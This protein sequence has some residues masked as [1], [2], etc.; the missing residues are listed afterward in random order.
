MHCPD[1]LGLA[2]IYQDS[3][4]GVPF[5]GYF[6]AVERPR[7]TGFSF[8]VLNQTLFVNAGKL[9]A[10]ANQTAFCIGDTVRLSAFGGGSDRFIWSG[11][12]INWLNSD[13]GASTYFVAQHA[14]NFT[15]Y[16]RG[17]SQCNVKDTSITVSI[18]NIPTATLTTT[19]TLLCETA[20]LTA[21]ATHATRYTWHKNDTLIAT[22]DQPYWFI[23]SGGTYKVNAANA[24][25]SASSSIL[26]KEQALSNTVFSSVSACEKYVLGK[27]TISK[28]GNYSIKVGNE[29]TGCSLYQLAVQIYPNSATTVLQDS[30]F[31]TEVPYL[32]QGQ[33]LYESGTYQAKLTN[34]FGCDSLVTLSLTVNEDL[35]IPNILTPQNP[36]FQIKNYE[37]FSPMNLK[38]Y[39][40]WGKLI[41]ESNDYRNDWSSTNLPLGTYFI[42]LTTRTGKVHKG[43]VQI[44]K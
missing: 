30:I 14:G 23:R 11:D 3:A 20:Q 16:V 33:S 25:C 39:N 42:H 5:A 12:S 28:S 31:D 41:F 36:T 22:T 24:G 37:F 27:D 7:N 1:N 8:P 18:F 6:P 4:I 21:V 2:C 17:L 38:I 10:I 19:N 40:R 35:F 29:Q 15:F 13:T 43:W 32:F 26:I 34:Q 44:V 9:Q